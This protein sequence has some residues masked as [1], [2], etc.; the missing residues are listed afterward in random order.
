MNITLD[1]YISEIESI[2]KEI[3]RLNV[4]IKNLRNQK[5]DAQK[6]LYEYMTEVEINEYKGYKITKLLQKP[7]V[8][9]KKKKDKIK[10]GIAVLRN[11]G[12]PNPEKTYKQIM[13]AQRSK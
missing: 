12:D 7:R 9:S 10:D 1:S 13:D 2:K 11:I 6:F 3:S 4:E 8:K 5:I